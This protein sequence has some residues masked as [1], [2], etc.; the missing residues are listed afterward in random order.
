MSCLLIFGYYLLQTGSAGISPNLSSFVIFFIL[1]IH[2][3]FGCK[4]FSSLWIID[5][6]V[7]KTSACPFLPW[8]LSLVVV[9]V[10]RVC[11]HVYE[12]LRLRT[13]LLFSL[14]PLDKKS[15]GHYFVF[16]SDCSQFYFFLAVYV[17]WVGFE[18]FFSCFKLIINLRIYV[19]AG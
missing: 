15:A 4:T 5:F 9:H 19:T 10:K 1:G 18:I 7:D 3:S 17:G 13:F 2:W 6:C 14:H 11:L 12:L 16:L 8:C